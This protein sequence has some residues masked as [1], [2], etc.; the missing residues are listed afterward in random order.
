MGSQTACDFTKVVIR[1]L[2]PTLQ[3]AD[4]KAAIDKEFADRYSWFSFARGKV[5]CVICMLLQRPLRRV[6]RAHR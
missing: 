6:S 3:E 4:C 2:P 1:Q 5:G